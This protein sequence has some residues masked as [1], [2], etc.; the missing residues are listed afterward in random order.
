MQRLPLPTL[1]L[2][3]ACGPNT[4]I[5]SSTDCMESGGI[6]LWQLKRPAVGDYRVIVDT[7]APETAFDPG[8]I[9]GT[10]WDTT[11]TI[12]AEV[13]D[14]VYEIASNDD[15]FPCTYPPPRYE[16]PTTDFSIDDPDDAPLIAVIILGACA[17]EG[18]TATY[19]LSVKRDDKPVSVELLHSFNW[20]LPDET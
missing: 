1:L 2:L 9:I 20:T 3:A 11:S 12:P 15:A 13:F 5:Q 16:C 18:G 10:G 14:R 4:P 8:L 19:E 17:T 7:V 6:E